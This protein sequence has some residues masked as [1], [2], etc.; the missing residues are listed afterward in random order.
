MGIL[1][2]KNGNRA[3]LTVIVASIVLMGIGLIFSGIIMNYTRL[4]LGI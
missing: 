1:A 2:A 3:G 4:L